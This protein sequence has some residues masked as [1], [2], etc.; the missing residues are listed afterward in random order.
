MI[1]KKK[2]I[3]VCV[4]IFIVLPLLVLGCSEEE[5]VNPDN[6]AEVIKLEK[7]AVLKSEDGE[8]NLYN[9]R[10]YNYNKMNIN[11]TILAYDKSSS[12]Y[13]CEEDG[14]HYI[15][16]DNKKYKIKDKRYEGLKLSPHGKYI[17]Y[18]VDDDG[19]KLKIFKNDSK[20]SEIKINSEVLISGTLYDWYDDNTIVYYGVKNDKTNGLFIYDI[21]KDKEE[22]IYTVEE[23]YL[24][25]LKRSMDSL[26]FLQ[27]NFK[28]D[29]ELVVIDKKSNQTNILSRYIEELNDVIE[30]DKKFYF[31]GKI[32]DDSKSLYKIEDNN[33]ERLVF[34]FPAAIDAE[35]GLKADDEENILFVG[36]NGIYG[37]YENIYSYNKDGSVS[38]VSDEGI[39]YIFIDYRE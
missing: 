12:S 3:F 11:S 39:D 31:T 19:L 23:G 24:V 38:V 16:Y 4:F 8:Y 20:N 29:K 21:I 30:I 10:D 18:F 9:Y 2:R 17:S 13:I 6:L 36:K 14:E 32:K 33:I 34:D 25:Y 26:I 22:L 1:S 5:K 27:M 7:G 28:N 35:K 15:V 37:K